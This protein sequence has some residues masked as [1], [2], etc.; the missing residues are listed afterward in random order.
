MR[1]RRSGRSVDLHLHAGGGD[2]RSRGYEGTGVE[3]CG[4]G[5]ECHDCGLDI[6]LWSPSVGL[7]C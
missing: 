1:Y 5:V 6:V 3:L 7:F 4:R 2:E